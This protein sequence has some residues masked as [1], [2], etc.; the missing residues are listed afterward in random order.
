M[1]N[2]FTLAINYTKPIHEMCVES[3]LRHNPTA[4]VF[5]S[6]DEICDLPGGGAFVD[7]FQHFSMVHFSDVFRVWYL[8]NFGGTWVD[9]DVIHM[10]PFDFPYD[11]P[12]NSFCITYECSA[13]QAVT[14]SL[15]HV[16]EPG[17]K[18]LRLLF[19]RQCGLAKDKGP[20]RLQYLDMGAWSI[21]YLMSHNLIDPYIAPHWEYQYL[22]WYDKYR[23]VE[24]RHW[25]QFQFDR[26][27][28][29][30]NSY[31]WHL[32]NAVIDM[33]INDTR[34]GLLSFPTFLSFLLVRALTNGF[35]ND[36]HIS[37]LDRLP[38]IHA[39][40]KIVEVGVYKGEHIAV[41]GQQ[42]TNA[43]LYAVDKWKSDSS[44]D[45]LASGDIIAY[46]S[47]E[48]HEKTYQTY[49]DNTWFL[50]DQKRIQTIRKGSVEA[51]CQFADNYLD[52]VYI[53]ADH[54][55]S[56]AKQDMEAWYPKVKPG[57][58]LSGHDYECPGI[59][60]VA[61]ALKDFCSEKGLSFELGDYYTWFVRKPE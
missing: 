16:N 28:Y 37:V 26:S 19:E 61:S 46:D 24:Q 56:G 7:Q 52:L 50:H 11:Y 22:P 44:S 31:G 5:R 13:R 6:I 8:L 21:S 33:A 12:K 60:D 10:R 51:S 39:P 43:S 41:L 29:N 32:T 54:S 4:K 30:P 20:A 17:N 55:Y 53:D 14:Q 34:E 47:D 59:G 36:S 38:L 23:F 27:I 1:F 57:G 35:I 48:A 42:R 45:Y 2:L 9:A 40:Y 3:L 49:L 15:M 25:R 18:D 58:W